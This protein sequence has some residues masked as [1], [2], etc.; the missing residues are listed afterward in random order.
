M[1]FTSTL[2]LYSH[3]QVRLRNQRLQSLAFT[4]AGV[5]Q[6][7]PLPALNCRRTRSSRGRFGSFVVRASS[8]VEGTRPR[9]AGSRRVY[10]Q[11]QANAPLSSAPVK[12]IAN[13]VGP[14]AVLVALTFDFIIVVVLTCFQLTVIWKLVEKLLV[15]AP[16]QQLKSSPVESQPP[17]QGLKWSFAAGTNLLSQLGAKI[18]RQSKQKLNE[19]ARELR[20]FPSIDMSGRNF[21]DEGLFF[22]AESLAFNQVE[23]GSLR[24]RPNVEFKAQKVISLLQE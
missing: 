3:P 9:A 6:F 14:F 13:V 16:K 17:S 12:Q 22:L 2:S 24:L 5:A 10:R 4:A 19:F 8:S 11:S 15:P 7:A 20:A 18:E 21:G 23:L 1:A